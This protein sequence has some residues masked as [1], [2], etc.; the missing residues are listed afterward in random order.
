MQSHIKEAII[1]AV[2]IL[3]LGAFIY[4]A[5][6]DTKDKERTV[7]VRGLSERIMPADFVIM[8]VVFTN[9]A[10]DLDQLYSSIQANTDSVK[11]FLIKNGIEE[12]EITV[13]AP[14]IEDI[15]NS[16]YTGKTKFRY[17]STT[18]VTIA[19]NKIEKV[20][21]FS[22]RL[23]EMI[24]QGVAITTNHWQFPTSY[25]Y[26]KLNDIKP[27][28]IEEATKNA[29]NSAIKF[30]MDSQSKL[31]KIKK[32]SQGTFSIENRDENSPNIKKLRV[33]TNIEYYL[34]N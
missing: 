18:A 10:N 28:M 11:N 27:E 19:T 25:Q 33:I 14:S 17:R 3:G 15:E 31:G 32:A 4:N 2:G 29:R 24:K 1:F 20:R 34:K 12:N 21:D 16:G 5:A 13:G 6:I 26:T 7:T 9:A 23:S 8:P 22:N 30:A